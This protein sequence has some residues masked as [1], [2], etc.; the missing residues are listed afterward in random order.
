MIILQW[1]KRAGDAGA[2]SIF[3]CKRIRQNI[4]RPTG[5]VTGKG[6]FILPKINRSPGDD[7][8]PGKQHTNK[9]KEENCMREH[10]GLQVFNE[11]RD[12]GLIERVN[13]GLCKPSNICVKD[14]S[15]F[16]EWESWTVQNGNPGVPQMGISDNRKWEGNNTDNN[17]N[18]EG[19]R[20]PHFM[21]KF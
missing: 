9:R 5:S 15:R 6:V 16:P 19:V 11:L 18:L 14:F 17:K 3:F 4:K 1:T 20:K 10:K 21:W 8:D 13:Q 2:E 7:P 12:I